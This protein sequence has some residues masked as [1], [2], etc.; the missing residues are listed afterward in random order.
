[1]LSLFKLYKKNS[2]QRKYHRLMKEAY[3]LSKV[4]PEESLKKQ[5]EAREI[6]LQIIANPL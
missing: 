5:R 6:Q 2:L 3:D 1:M 4:N